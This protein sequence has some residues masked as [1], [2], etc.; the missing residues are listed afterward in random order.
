M[1]ELSTGGQWGLFA[2]LTVLL[3]LAFVMWIKY[4]PRL[5][6]YRLKNF[7][8]NGINRRYTEL[9]KSRKDVV[10]HFFWAVDR[11]DTKEADMHEERVVD[12]DRKLEDLRAQY[13]LVEVDAP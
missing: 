10:Y 13:K 12:I 4:L 2:A 5:K 9:C 8:L 1:S 7:K 6:A 3:I 11:G